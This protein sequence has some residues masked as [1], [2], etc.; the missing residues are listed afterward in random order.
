MKSR[1]EKTKSKKWTQKRIA[2]WS[3]VAFILIIG[4]N[5]ANTPTLEEAKQN[6]I[7]KIQQ[8]KTDAKQEQYLSLEYSSDVAYVGNSKDDNIKPGTYVFDA[9]EF[10]AQAKHGSIVHYSEKDDFG[11]YEVPVAIT[12]NLGLDKEYFNKKEQFD[13][14]TISKEQHGQIMLTLQEGDIIQLKGTDG[15]KLY[16]REVK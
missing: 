5:V 11:N 6:A 1:R 3:A 8:E 7:Q 13:F 4:I 2:K 10:S 9:R 15:E 16:Y 12:S 14:E